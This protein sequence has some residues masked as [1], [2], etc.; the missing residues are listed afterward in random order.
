MGASDSLFLE[1]GASYTGVF[2]LSKFIKLYTYH[3]FFSIGI[4]SFNKKIFFK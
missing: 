3:I 2:S 1:L 4:L